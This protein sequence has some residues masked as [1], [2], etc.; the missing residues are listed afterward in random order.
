MFLVLAAAIQILTSCNDEYVGIKELTGANSFNQISPKESRIRKRNTVLIYMAADNSLESY[1]IDNKTNLLN[2]YAPSA[3]DDEDVL[4]LYFD[5]QNTAPVLE[6]ITSNGSATSEE[7][8]KTYPESQNSASDTT[9]NEV[10]TDAKLLFPASR[11][12]L[13]LWSHGNGWLPTGYYYDPEN[14]TSFS[15]TSRSSTLES[16]PAYAVGREYFPPLEEDPYRNFVK[17]FAE[18]DGSEIDIP[19]LADAL[20]QYYDYIIFDA[21]LM[22]GVEIAYELKDKCSYIAF[23]PAEVLGDGL[24][25]YGSA[26]QY[27][28]DEDYSVDAA[29]EKIL[30]DGFDYYDSQTGTYQSSTVSL[31]RCSALDSLASSCKSIFSAHRQE[32]NDGISEISLQ[33]YFRFNRH[34]FFDLEDFIKSLATT[35]ELISF[36]NALSNTVIYKES[37]PAFLSFTINT[38]CGLSSYVYEPS[39][40]YL[41]AFYETLLWNDATGMVPQISGTYLNSTVK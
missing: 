11:N 14:F 40:T 23:S 9:L 19:Q 25:S 27:L 15:M 29:L 33:G 5:I 20:P 39:S 2:G 30:Q 13:V 10:L 28:F 3:N 26:M 1:A 4:L 34:W 17:S 18:H 38:Y 37:T 22:G 6:R 32:L 8:L 31:V 7:I 24:I 12:G 36:E 41:N 21:C 16:S 35:D